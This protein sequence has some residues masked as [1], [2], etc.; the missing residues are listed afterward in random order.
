MQGWDG[1]ESPFLKHFY[2]A[3]AFIFQNVIVLPSE[4]SE[5][6]KALNRFSMRNN[7]SSYLSGAAGSKSANAA[8]PYGTPCS[9]YR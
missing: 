2:V 6:H 1:V 9:I 3:L 8:V 7:G 5:L 4:H